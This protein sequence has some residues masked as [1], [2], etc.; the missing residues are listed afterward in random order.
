MIH[1]KFDYFNSIF[2]SAAFGTENIR[3][4]TS[5]NVNNK[6]IFGVK[7]Q[8]IIRPKFSKM[9]AVGTAIDI[10]TAIVLISSCTNWA[11]EHANC[12]LKAGHELTVSM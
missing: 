9:T 5:K 3:T 4:A 7:P 1:I 6:C 8:R 10:E 12:K 2:F 11:I